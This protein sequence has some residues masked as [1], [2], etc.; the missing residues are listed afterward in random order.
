MDMFTAVLAPVPARNRQIENTVKKAE[1]LLKQNHRITWFL[2]WFKFAI[3]SNENAV[4]RKIG[5][6]LLDREIVKYNKKTRGA[7][8]SRKS[9]ITWHPYVF[10]P[11]LLQTLQHFMDLNI[12]PINS[13]SFQWQDPTELTTKLAEIETEYFEG[14]MGLISVTRK[15]FIKIDDTWTWFDLE[16]NN[17]PEEKGAMGH[18]AADEQQYVLLS[19]REKHVIKG[20]TYWKSHLTISFDPKSGWIGQSKGPKNIKPDKKYHSMIV[21]LLMDKRVKRIK[22]GGHNPQDNFAIADLSPKLQKDLFKRKPEFEATGTLFQQLAQ[23][24]DKKI[25]AQFMQNVSNEYIQSSNLIVVQKDIFGHFVEQWLE[26]DEGDINV[27]D[28]EFMEALMLNPIQ[29]LFREHVLYDD[30]RQLMLNFKMDKPVID[31]KFY[32]QFE[33]NYQDFFEEIKQIFIKNMVMMYNSE[34]EMWREHSFSGQDEVSG[35][36]HETLFSDPYDSPGIIFIPEYNNKFNEQTKACV[37]AESL[38]SILAE[39]GEN[40]EDEDDFEINVLDKMSTQLYI[41]EVEMDSYAIR[42]RFLDTTDF[43]KDLEDLL[44]R[45]EI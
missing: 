16:T 22:G 19:L 44:E 21:K 2:R 25:F 8:I 23:T 32:K 28:S 15:E 5:G 1:R 33:L 43:E 18:C 10:D 24:F 36:Y 40:F 31:E 37:D 38:I 45:F 13:Y 12:P 30:D 11:Q 42:D 35:W 29:K 34:A 17:S 26:F 4:D 3:L 7:K 14:K 41:N 20:N 6:D 9:L 39:S 27:D